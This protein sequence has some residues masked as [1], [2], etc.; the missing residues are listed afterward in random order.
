VV[1]TPVQ[2][3]IRLR[4]SLLNKE[5]KDPGEVSE[6]MICA[7]DEIGLGSSHEGIMVLPADTRTGM[8]AKEYF[9]IEE[10]IIFEI[11]LT[12][13]RAD[14]ASH[15]GVARDLLAL[16]NNP[17]GE[18]GRMEPLTLTIPSVE[19]FHAGSQV[20]PVTVEVEDHVACPRY[21][22]ITI[23]GVAVGDSPVW[24]KNRLKSIG[25]APINNIVDVTNYVLH[26]LGQP[27]HAFDAD[28]IK[29][30]KVV[31]RH[32]REGEKFITLD[33]VERILAS[34]DLMICNTEEPMCIAGVFGGIRSGISSNTK[35]VF[36]ESAHFSP[37][38]IRKTSKRHGLK[39][40]ASF[41]FERGT[42][43]EITVY[44]MQRAAILIMQVAGGE[45]SSGITDIYPNPFRQENVFLPYSYMDMIIGEVLDRGRVKNILHSLNIY[46]EKEN[47]EGLVLSI[48]THKSDVTRPVDVVEEILRIYGYNNIA[49]PRMLHSSL[50]N[51]MKKDPEKTR[52]AAANYLTGNGFYELMTNSLTSDAYASANEEK[53]VKV[54]NALSKDH[55]TMRQSMLFSGLEAISYNKNRKQHDLRMFEFGKTY[56]E[57]NGTYSEK[58]HLALYITGNKFA[59]AWNADKGQSDFFYLKGF[60]TNVLTRI[61]IDPRSLK[62]ESYNHKQFSESLVWQKNEKAV[63]TFGGVNAAILKTFDI[64]Q[65]VWYADFDMDHILRLV[66]G[67]PAVYNEI[68][69]YPQVKRDLSMVIGRDVTF[70]QIEALAFSAEKN[71]L[72]EVQLFDVYEGDKI[73]AGKK[74]YAM[75][76]ILLDERQTLT[77]KQIDKTMNRLM[78]VFEKEA[79]AVI[80]KQ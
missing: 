35:N 58:N 2:S 22:G 41:R 23:S 1:A 36:L 54:I 9:G 14:A 67:K 31:V 20:N 46:I 80:R 11:G 3:Y 66:S 50:G 74:S 26:E 25:L 57:D 6:G 38:S 49:L 79:G 68:S 69:K 27:L 61:G 17:A 28:E 39:T 72:K 4:E 48:P 34:G 15:L 24:L 5:I 10:D 33:K 21:T 62:S 44:A 16:L 55:D 43:P 30:G 77:E 52:E 32:A 75:S 56:S 45:I 71:L 59:H 76:F 13:N 73:E 42:D 65:P 70:A 51:P 29:G 40:D 63:V 78:E 7:E 19:D 37:A 12:P 18:S 47:E 53:P 64:T 8:S 60:V